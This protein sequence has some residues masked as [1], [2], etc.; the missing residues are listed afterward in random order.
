MTADLHSHASCTGIQDQ[1]SS[2]S[3]KTHEE[4]DLLRGSAPPPA[5]A[6]T[7]ASLSYKPLGIDKVA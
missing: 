1:T 4:E 5:P 7:L 2:L 6:P 3:M